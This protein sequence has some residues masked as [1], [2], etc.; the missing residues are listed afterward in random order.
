MF[1]LKKVTVS[2][3]EPKAKKN[4]INEV[5]LLSL[6]KHPNVVGLIEVFYDEFID[7]LWY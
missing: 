4:A 7:S 2:K 1:A 5:K 3:M 6:I